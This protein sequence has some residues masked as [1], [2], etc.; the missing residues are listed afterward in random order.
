MTSPAVLL[1]TSLL[2]A[3]I[4]CIER[5]PSPAD[6]DEIAIAA[7]APA[8]DW[9]W[10]QGQRAGGHRT[11]FLVNVTSGAWR[12]V[13]FGPA[14]AFS[15]NGRHAASVEYDDAGAHL[16]L[17]SLEGAMP[18]VVEIPVETEGPGWHHLAFTPGGG[19]VELRQAA[20]G[21]CVVSRRKLPTGDAVWQV[22]LDGVFFPGVA[23]GPADE[24]RLYRRRADGAAI[25]RLSLIDGTATVTGTVD[26]AATAIRPNAEGD[27]FL[28]FAV[29]AERRASLRLHDGDDGNR[30]ATLVAE[31]A[32]VDGAFL[33]D[34]RLAI[35]RV[36]GQEAV[37]TVHDQEGSEE[38]RI[39]LG[40]TAAAAV[41]GE[42][43]PGRV[44]LEL[45]GPS[46][47][48][49]VLTVDLRTGAVRRYPDL[50]LPLRAWVR[51]SRPNPTGT[52]GVTLVLTA[53]KRLARLDR[54]G[55][56]RELPLPR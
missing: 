42:V 44:L 37:L 49:E 7:A 36:D 32:A 25:V 28:A 11:A 17:V 22:S 50:S 8:G 23:F 27:R 33:G 24:A 38:T 39:A 10:I 56:V 40:R 52:S 43:A 47:R 12:Q 54:D 3:G 21:A 15:A 14:A 13:G 2:L 26:G 19:L 31:A 29:T 5:S 55:S 53:A 46:W 16:H 9:V 30:L 41:G 48:K 35:T 20:Q 1:G 6:L 34:G 51:A 18:T 45:R 4:G